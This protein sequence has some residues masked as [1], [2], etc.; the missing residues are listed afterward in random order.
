[1]ENESNSKEIIETY[2]HGIL[3][4]ISAL[5]RKMCVDQVF[6]KHMGCE[7]GRTPDLPYGLQAIMM[8]TNLCDGGYRPLHILQEYFQE[9][10]LE[11]IF[12]HN[13]PLSQ[14]NE[15]RFGY[16]LEAVYQ[17]GPRRIFTELS[18]LVFLKYGIKVKSVNYDTTSLIMWGKYNS[19]DGKT[20]IIEIT[21][22]HSK[23]K[24]PDKKQIKMG[25][26]V[27]EGVV[28]D[29]KVLS[30]NKDDKTYNYENIEDSIKMAERLGTSADEFY[31]VADSALFTAKNLEKLHGENGCK[32]I[33]RIPDS[34]KV[35]S[36]LIDKG[37]EDE[38]SEEV[39]YTNKHDEK[40]KYKIHDQIM[41][42]EGY[43]IKCVL[44]YSESLKPVKTE[45]IKK[46][47]LAEYETLKE[48][49]DKYG[50]AL[51]ESIEK[52]MGDANKI[53]KLKYHHIAFTVQ[54]IAVNKRG[55]PSKKNPDN[56]KT[57]KYKIV[58]QILTNTEA[59]GKI[60]ERECMFVLATNDLEKSGRDI[61]LEYKTQSSVEK[62]FQ[63]LKSPHFVNTLYLN[64]PERIEALCYILLIT[65]M[66]LS[67]MEHQVRKGLKADNSTVIGPGKVIMSN[68]TLKAIAGI[69]NN[70][71]IQRVNS[72][73]YMHWS[74]FKPLTESQVR[75]LKC[76]DMPEKLLLHKI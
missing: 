60:I 25:I 45:K 44:A 19:S 21:F 48:Q 41:E 49:A 70:M 59:V 18:T 15:D 33:T 36:G 26:G 16:F 67:V 35:A 2:D 54:E 14:V 52:A 1:V 39:I 4:F 75:V 5:C 12:H 6:D 7:K 55:R 32:Y 50:G 57:L 51:Y 66:I 76:L 11:G 42:Y 73:G 69:F 8:I 43:P 13:I 3:Y 10:D 27:A 64:T 20:G 74:F 58:T 71:R 17:A 65:L 68:P 47:V 24:R 28:V 46:K 72:K 40:I 62:K 30:G 61:L 22:G 56:Q 38:R 9:K 53:G 37:L 23:Q 63:Q 31:Y 29:A 34:Y